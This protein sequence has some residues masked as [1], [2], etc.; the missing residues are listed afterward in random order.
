MLLLVFHVSQT[1]GTGT[2]L[3]IPKW[4]S[5]QHTEVQP[6]NHNSPPAC[7]HPPKME[8]D[9]WEEVHVNLEVGWLVGNLSCSITTTF[10]FQES[11]KLIKS[12]R[13]W[14]SEKDQVSSVSV[15]SLEHVL[16]P[17]SHHPSHFRI[18]PFLLILHLMVLLRDIHKA[19]L[20]T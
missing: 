16:N 8:R 11:W 9:S 14:V 6:G 19:H 17:E 13:K 20:L 3:L 4:P 18:Y 2:A 5:H 10:P 1:Q 7:T 15:K 12:R